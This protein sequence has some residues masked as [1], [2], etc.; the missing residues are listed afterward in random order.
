MVTVNQILSKE[1]AEYRKRVEESGDI[2]MGPDGKAYR[3][4][5][6]TYTQ[7]LEF[8]VAQYRVKQYKD[9]GETYDHPE[10]TD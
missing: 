6:F 4:Q 10:H 5:P 1:Y 3:G 7:Y 8:L 9:T 2:R